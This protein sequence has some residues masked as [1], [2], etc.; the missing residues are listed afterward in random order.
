MP[1]LARF[2]EAPIAEHRKRKVAAYARVSTD[3]DEQFTSYEAQIDYY[4]QYIKAR[5]DWEFVQVYTD[6]GIT[7]TSTKHREGFKQMVADALEGKIDLIV[8][9]SVSRFARNTVDSLTTIRQLKDKGVECFFEKENIWTF[10][11]KGELL[12]TIMS[13]L[14]QEESRSISENCTW[15]QRK[16]MADGRVSVPFDHFLGYERGE[17][18]ELVINEEQA[19]TVRL[20]YDLFLQGLTP[21]TIANR[22]TAMGILTPRRKAKWNQGTVRSILTN[23]KYKGDALM[24]KCYTADFLTKKQVPNNGVLPQYYVE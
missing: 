16:R 23:E 19:K 4:T 12:I 7:G 17:N 20:I 14:A 13:S 15:G 6:E 21:H 10:D 24:Q 1:T 8:T 2:T 5:D 9:K 22:L 11:G 3:S 18:G